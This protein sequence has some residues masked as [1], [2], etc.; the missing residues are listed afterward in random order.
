MGRRAKG[1][2]AGTNTTARDKK[3]AAKR[4]LMSLAVSWR[5]HRCEYKPRSS[6]LEEYDINA[7]RALGM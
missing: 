4:R 1:G 2:S 5:R 7:K 3:V 6:Q